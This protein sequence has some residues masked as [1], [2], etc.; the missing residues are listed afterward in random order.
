MKHVLVALAFA[1]IAIVCPVANSQGF[2]NKPV[3]ILVP[4]SP[5]TAADITARLLG[6]RLAEMWGQGV[7]IENQAG[8]GGNIGAVAVAKAAPDGYTL[9]MLGINH[10]INPF[11]YK[12]IPY[13][14][15][16]DFK[17]IARVAVAPL[18][19]VASAKFPPNTIA[20]LVALAKAKPNTIVYGSG[21]NGSVTQLSLELLKSLA[22]IEMTHVPYKS[23][24]P[25]LND[26]LGNQISLGSPAAASVV[27]HA[28]AGTMKV[29]A[30][31]TAKRSSVFPNVPTVA[32]QGFPSY[33]VATW[34]GL[35]APA[36]TPDAIV[37][38]IYADVAKIAQSKEFIDQ[39]R[40][41]A[42]DVELLGPAAFRTFLS[43]ELD[44]W[45]ALVKTSGA[46]L[47]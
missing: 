45:A 8:A 36:R 26:I 3:K 43:S 29:L 4:F 40:P 14:L 23:V 9:L 32:E 46:K 28:Q 24:A 20:E 27:Q 34:N 11:L 1:T 17:P 13:D 6:S 44:K 15:A 38:K 10:V 22:G 41:Q 5:G 37:D 18:A 7:V 42:L 19:I 47:D 2:P 30:I 35:L 31:T 12:D 33:D 16:R 21:G 39:L 25:M